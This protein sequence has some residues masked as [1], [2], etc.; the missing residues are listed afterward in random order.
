M[1]DENRK[2]QA[3]N[4]RDAGGSPA[5]QFILATYGVEQ[6]G[7]EFF[8]IERIKNRIGT[9]VY[10]PMPESFVEPLM[11]ELGDIVRGSERIFRL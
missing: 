8:V 2:T 11:K 1:M 4:S 9:T 7:D 6:V 10:G 3:V 5:H